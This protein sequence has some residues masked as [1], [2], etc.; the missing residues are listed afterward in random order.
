MEGKVPNLQPYSKEVHY[1]LERLLKE[2][3]PS[4]DTRI[5]E[6]KL[7]NEKDNGKYEDNQWLIM[8]DYSVCGVVSKNIPTWLPRVVAA[9]AADWDSYGVEDIS[10]IF[11]TGS[12][13]GYNE[14]AQVLGVLKGKPSDLI[15]AFIMNQCALHV[16]VGVPKDLRVLKELAVLIV[17]YESEISKLHPHCRR[18]EHPNARYA[19]ESNHSFTKTKKTKLDIHTVISTSQ[20]EHLQDNQR[21]S[22]PVLDPRSVRA[23]HRRNWHS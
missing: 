5:E 23:R 14:I 6:S 18:P 21:I 9:K 10:P 19:V 8:H 11:N 17:I 16:H 22:Q 15:G 20:T 13:Q 2:K 3:C 7:I 1:V 4:I 12:N